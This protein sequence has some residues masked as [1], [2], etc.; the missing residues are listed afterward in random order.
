VDDDNDCIDDITGEDADAGADET[1]E[2]GDCEAANGVLAGAELERATLVGDDC[3]ACVSDCPGTVS[4]DICER[5]SLS[6]SDAGGLS[7]SCAAT[8]EA[9][10]PA[11]RLIAPGNRLLIIYDTLRRI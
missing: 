6:S 3:D 8:T 5:S 4:V 11:S 9:C 1:I 2:L 7:A 10:P